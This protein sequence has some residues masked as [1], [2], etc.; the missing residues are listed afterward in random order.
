MVQILCRAIPGKQGNKNVTRELNADCSY[1]L[2]IE[3]V[4]GKMLYSDINQIKWEIHFRK[5]VLCLTV[6]HEG[7]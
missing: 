6:S 5:K 1:R 4:T 7:I 3:L 2:D